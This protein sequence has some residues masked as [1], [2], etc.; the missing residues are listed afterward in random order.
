MDTEDDPVGLITP[1]TG[2]KFEFVDR[3]GLE[4][5]SRGEGSDAE[6]DDGVREE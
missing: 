3:P 1:G 5:P 2:S 6:G 4:L